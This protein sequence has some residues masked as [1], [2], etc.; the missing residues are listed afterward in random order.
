MWIGSLAVLSFLYWVV[1]YGGLI[2]VLTWSLS[3]TVGLVAAAFIVLAVSLS[4]GFLEQLP[5]VLAVGLCFIALR[6]DRPAQGMNVLAYGGG[7]LCA[8]EPLVKLSFG[9]VVLILLLAMVGARADRR[10]WAGFLGTAIVSFLVLWFATGQGLGNLWDYADNGAQIIKGYGE[11][12]GYDAAETW[13][14]V[15]IVLGALALT[16]F[17]HRARFRD[18]RAK[19]FATAITA[20]VAYTVF[21]YGTT[22]FAKSGPPVTAMSTLLAI[23]LF[24]P[25]PRRL[26]PGFVAATVVFCVLIFHAAGTSAGVDV[27]GRA[28]TFKES[29]EFA[30]RPGLR[31][32]KI[33]EE[34]ESLRTTLAVPEPVLKALAGKTVAIEPWEI[35]VAWAYELDWKPMPVFQN[36]QDYTQQLDQLNAETAEDAENGPQTL[37]RQMPGGTAVTGGRPNF[38]E[39]QPAWDPPEQ[40]YADFCNFVP[41]L[42][43]GSWQV[44]SRIP[45][46]CG[47][48]KLAMSVTVDPGQ[49]FQIPQAGN[50]E[51]VTMRVH[52]MKLEGL[53]KLLTLFWRP[54]ER[55]AI[56]DGGEFT[57]RLPP[58][59]TEDPMIVSADRRLGHG[60]ELPELPPLHSM[61]LEGASGPFKV[62]FYRVKLKKTG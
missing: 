26:A 10:Q 41:T 44:L 49:S 21:K 31:H 61:F 15:L 56:A 25:W 7:L 53:E 22:Q 6:E 38:F 52:G 46:R 2:A 9:P 45:D 57:Y 33:T 4:F 30:I 32:Q 18:T 24:A 62:D 47:E 29:V 16:A 39:R 40:S 48:P 43:E 3:R 5:V 14:A 55:H 34:R 60:P 54:S 58:D 23:F 12:M 36:Y 35:T 37:L 27:I 42:T 59:T 51:I 8:V 19:W 11:A 1:T 20:V 13:E 17:I 50:H 28:E